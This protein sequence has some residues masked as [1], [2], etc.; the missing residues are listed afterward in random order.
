MGCGVQKVGT[1]SIRSV[2]KEDTSPSV[3][4][5]NTTNPSFHPSPSRPSLTRVNRKGETKDYFERDPVRPTRNREMTRDYSTI[6]DRC[7]LEENSELPYRLKPPSVELRLEYVYG[8]KNFAGGQNLF[9]TVN[10]DVIVYPSGSMVVLLDKTSNSQRFLGAGDLR[11]VGSHSDDILSLTVSEDRS[12]V[13]TGEIGNNP[14][15]CVWKLGE[16]TQPI[17]SFDQGEDSLG[18]GILKFSS[19]AKL[20]LAVDISSDQRIRVFDLRFTCDIIYSSSAGKTRIIACAWS[21]KSLKFAAVSPL[22]FW[23]KENGNH[24]ECSQINSNVVC[25]MMVVGWMSTGN[26]ITG[27]KDG[28]LYLWSDY[29]VI[30]TVQVLTSNSSIEALTVVK[31]FIVTGG[32]DHTVHLLDA[33]FKEIMQ[34]DVP[35]CPR[36]LDVSDKTILCGTRDGTIQELKGHSR[37]LLMESHSEGEIWAAG[38]DP[39]DKN[40]LITAGDDNKIRCWDLSQRK[41]VNTGIIET[42]LFTPSDAASSPL[43]PNQQSRALCI[44]TE[45]HIAVGHLDGHATIRQNRLQL[46]NILAVLRDA[47]DGVMVMRYAPS[48]SFLAVG[49]NDFHAY[50]Y[51]V[52]SGYNLFFTLTGHSDPVISIDWSVD[53][54]MVKTCSIDGELIHW[55]VQSESKIDSM[56][57]RVL[58][59]QWVTW[60]SASG[61]PVRGVNQVTEEPAFITCVNR[62]NEQKYVVVGNE[63]GLLELYRYPNGPGSQG[64]IY[65]AHSLEVVNLLWTA[66]DRGLLSLGG[67]DLSILQWR[68]TSNLLAFAS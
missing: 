15:I 66:Q 42:P 13:A 19:D 3:R 67:F 7:L 31:D 49:S 8:Y 44:S 64:K 45:G 51:D 39:K 63:W 9:Y 4:T 41:C 29:K 17:H 68:V 46:N 48:A 6:R 25:D 27:G 5:S 26:C 62:S 30:K 28:R 60:T 35:S 37:T 14:M 24:F 22:R 61:W 58:N 52:K 21:P 11:E 34:V 55:D 53:E 54:S 56:E 32:S 10:P 47:R 2:D 20:L 12:Y 16:W 1:Q 40:M 65:R 36:S 23:E 33:V 43:L 50:I 59:E 38:L 57:D 18:V